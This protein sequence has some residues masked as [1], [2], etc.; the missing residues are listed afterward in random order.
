MRRTVT[1][2]LAELSSIWDKLQTSHS[3]YCRHAGVGLGSSESREYV[4]D[5]GKL[6]DLA[7]GAAETVLG[8]EDPD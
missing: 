7:E 6:K 1:K 4:R 3:F 8:E 2:K 5:V